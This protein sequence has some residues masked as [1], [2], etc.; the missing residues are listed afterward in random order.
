MLTAFAVGFNVRV[1]LFSSPSMKF[2]SENPSWGYDQIQGTL[3]NRG[4]S[5]F[6]QSVGILKEHVIAP[7]PKRTKKSS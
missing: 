2:G 4:H 7:A 1:L 5:V 6:D 3:T